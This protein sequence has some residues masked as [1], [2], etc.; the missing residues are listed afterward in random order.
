MDIHFVTVEVGIVRR[1]NANVQSEGL[2]WPHFDL[3][4]HN[5]DFVQRG[6]SIEEHNISV[7]EVS[8]H[9]VTN[10]KV[11]GDFVQLR[12]LQCLLFLTKENK[13]CA[14]KDELE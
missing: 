1:A 2:P 3:V 9:N 4:R 10:A 11:L 12:I 8:F 7:V 6:L 14:W 5:T 13:I